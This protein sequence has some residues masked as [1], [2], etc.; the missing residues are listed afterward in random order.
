MSGNVELM[1]VPPVPFAAELLGTVMVNV[2]AL[3]TVA[4]T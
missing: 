3:G 1:S 2:V 4:T